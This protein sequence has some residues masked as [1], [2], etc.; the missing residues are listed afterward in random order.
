MNN[1]TDKQHN[2]IRL[3]FLAGYFTYNME[4]PSVILILAIAFAKPFTRSSSN[5]DFKVCR[6]K[7]QETIMSLLMM[8][9]PN[10]NLSKR[11]NWCEQSLHVRYGVAFAVICFYSVLY[12]YPYIAYKHRQYYFDK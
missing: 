10:Y 1:I 4:S 8:I 12:V 6:H 11:A 5:A 3:I 7:Q 2:K 9:R